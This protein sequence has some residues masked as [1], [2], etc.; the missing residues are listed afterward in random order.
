MELGENDHLTGSGYSD[1]CRQKKLKE[2]HTWTLAKLQT[3]KDKKKK[4]ES[5][6][7]TGYITHKV[8]II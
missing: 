8:T 4:K 1:K 5:S 7:E 2:N 3:T 6:R